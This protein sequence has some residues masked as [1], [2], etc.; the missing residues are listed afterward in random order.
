MD[1]S[2]GLSKEDVRL[3]FENGENNYKVQ[4]STQTVGEIIKSNVFTY[5][6]LVFLVLA[7]LLAIA[8]AW[9]DMLFLPIIIA[10]TLI[11]IVQEVHSKKVLD[12]LSILNSP[13]TKTLRDGQ[14]VELSSEELVLDD[15]VIF[16]GR[17]SDTC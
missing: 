13:K 15:I 16:E 17:M 14:I 5:F 11:G 7:I 6:N 1:Y 3:K 8:S 12:N 2:K 9:R 4:S 10:N